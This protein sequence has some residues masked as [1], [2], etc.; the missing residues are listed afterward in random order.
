VS[1]SAGI[2]VKGLNQKILAFY[3]HPAANQASSTRLGAP[4]VD[5]VTRVR[6]PAGGDRGPA[7]HRLPAPPRPRGV[8]L[9]QGLGERD[10]GEF[11]YLGVRLREKRF[12]DEGILGADAVYAQSSRRATRCEVAPFDIGTDTGLLAR[13]DLLARKTSTAHNPCWCP[14]PRAT[15]PCLPIAPGPGRAGPRRTPTRLTKHFSRA[16]LRGNRPGRVTSSRRRPQALPVGGRQV[17]D[18]V[19]QGLSPLESQTSQ[20]HHFPDSPGMSSQR[21]SQHRRGFS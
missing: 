2:T 10:A 20:F 15:P 13:T 7:L 6:N 16:R 18:P 4:A 8:Q 14:F 21:Q 5:S 19:S 9:P 17:V 3:G 11:I 12:F 1:L